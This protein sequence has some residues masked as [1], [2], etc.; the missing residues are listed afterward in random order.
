[1]T[2]KVGT[3]YA[4]I[5]QR[6]GPPKPGQSR[7]V[8]LQKKR[9]GLSMAICACEVR[10]DGSPMGKVLV[11]TYAYADLP[12]GPHQLVA[13]ETLFPGE[14]RRDFTTAPGR[15]YFFLVKSSARHDAVSG[16]SLVGG[17]AGVAVA[18]VATSGHDNLGPGEFIPLDEPTARTMLAELQL[19]D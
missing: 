16:M 19:A 8:V 12:A 13:S 3:D 18:A 6:V 1:M 15:T 9:D 4:A 14:T 5:S 2:A 7:V 10:V 17:L 11:G